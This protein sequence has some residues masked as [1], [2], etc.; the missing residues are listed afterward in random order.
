[1]MFLLR[2]WI[3][4]VLYSLRRQVFSRKVFLAA[5]IF[6]LVLAITIG[7]GL[8]WEMT[9]RT[10]GEWFVLR[11]LGLFFVPITAIIFGAGAIGDERDDKTLVYLLTR[12]LARSGVYIGKL[13]AALPLAMLFAAGGLWLQCQSGRVFHQPELA[14][15]FPLYA[16]GILLGT[17]AYV[18]LFQLLSALFRHSSLIAT[19]YV[20]FMEVFIGNVPGV[21]KRI[22]VSFYMRS[23]VYEMA[24]A[25]GITPPPES[26]FLPV[27]A[28]TARMALAAGAAGFALLGVLVFTR[29]EYH[30]VG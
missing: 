22:T 21:M 29:R 30:D 14:D 5:A 26:F 9:P 19:A 16:E 15:S 8:Y 11:L 10:F 27:D 20:F 17:A 24:A 3:A 25:T 4:L 18:T 23:H 7:S 6:C 12:P 13:A 1:M 28:A 2:A